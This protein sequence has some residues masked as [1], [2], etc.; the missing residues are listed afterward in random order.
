MQIRTSLN[1]PIVVSLR[2]LRPED[3]SAFMAGHG[4]AS[5]AA[6]VETIWLEE[7]WRANCALQQAL[8]ASPEKLR[9]LVRVL[10][11]QQLSV[12]DGHTDLT[13]ASALTSV[14]EEEGLANWFLGDVG[15]SQLVHT[16]Y[17]VIDSIQLEFDVAAATVA[18]P[19][20]VEKQTGKVERIS[21]LGQRGADHGTAP[22]VTQPGKYGQPE[23]DTKGE[24][25]GLR[26]EPGEQEQ[27]G[28][29]DCPGHSAT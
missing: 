10:V 11:L 20:P 19:G 7:Y 15:S 1:L 18:P 5:G 28:V 23:A 16:A 27:P 2:A 9:D 13:L 6:P 17:E 26:N 4:K 24:R 22:G 21:D 3:A 14:I 12:E 8:L 29:K 25:Q